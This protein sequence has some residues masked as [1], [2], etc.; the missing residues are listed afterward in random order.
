MAVGSPVS[1]SGVRSEFGTGS[2]AL[3]G[4]V[5][6]GGYVANHENNAAISSTSNGLALSQFLNTDIDFESNAYTLAY[7]EFLDFITPNYE[8]KS[9]VW[10]SA[11]SSLAGVT[12]ADASGGSKGS[13]DYIGKAKFNL[14][15]ATIDSIFDFG[16]NDQFGPLND[17]AMFILS[18]DQRSTG[19][20]NEWSSVDVIGVSSLSRSSSVVPNGTYDA[21]W[22]VT[23][24]LWGTTFG[25]PLTASPGTAQIRVV[26]S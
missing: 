5:R 4:F 6:G 2:S 20:G 24:W 16:Q 23:Y 26:L 9:G 25:F 17:S 12:N 19:W 8:T 11:G 1:L 7:S 22:N 15:T 10:T 21:F 13:I 18:G 14:D 3:S